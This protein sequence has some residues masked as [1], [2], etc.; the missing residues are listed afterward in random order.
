MSRYID[1]DKT[2]KILAD[3]YISKSQKNFDI[4]NIIMDILTDIENMEIENVQSIKC[5]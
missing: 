3:K 2:I 4:F 5:D 1:L